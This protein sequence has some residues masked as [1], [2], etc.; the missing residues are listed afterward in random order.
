MDFVAARENMIDCQLRTNKVTDERIL[1]AMSSLPRERFVPRDRENMA[2]V[3]IDIPCGEGRCL[4]SAMVSARLVQEAGIQSKDE[5]LCIAAGTGYSVAVMSGMASSVI[6]LESNKECAAKAGE[7]FSELKL[8][9]AVVVEGPLTD[10]WQ[11]ESPYNV[12]FID[13]MIA[14]VPSEIFSQLSDGGRLVAIIDSGDGIG[15]ATLFVKLSGTVSSREI[16]DI[17][18][19]RLAEFD[20]KQEFVF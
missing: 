20:K 2:Y 3:D 16:F 12:I 10:G 19:G 6:A 7:L 9:N 17:C 11:A 8:D 14:E 18:V 13:G 15:R 1:N 4:M 5:V